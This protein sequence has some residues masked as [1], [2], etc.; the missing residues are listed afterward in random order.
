MTTYTAEVGNKLNDLLEKNYDAEKGYTKAAENVNHSG[1]KNFFNRKAEQRR[2]FGHDLKSEIKSFGQE[3]D[4]GG[5]VTGSAHRT[6]MDMKSWLSQDNE[7][8][9]LEEA[10][11]G[12][13]T[14]V[15]EYSEVL[16]ET[17]LPSSTKSILMSQKN[18]I[19]TDLAE[20]KSLE[21]LK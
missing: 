21:S 9:M 6:W 13:K 12:E 10:I 5:S 8:S 16:K 17:S 15:N 18:N 11:R 14:T 3:V 1:L 2:V 7:E 19:E 4:K 20:V